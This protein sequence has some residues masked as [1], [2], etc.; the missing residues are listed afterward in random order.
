MAGE[1]D[2]EV[3][4]VAR[5]GGQ[6]KEAVG[7]ADGLDAET[8]GFIAILGCNRRDAQYKECSNDEYECAANSMPHRRKSCH[9]VSSGQRGPDGALFR[10]RHPG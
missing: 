5:R 10:T 8:D 1:L 6:G 7:G 3:E 4:Y 9:R 2:F